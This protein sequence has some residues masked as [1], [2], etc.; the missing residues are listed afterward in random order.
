M[1]SELNNYKHIKKCHKKQ[2]L[3]QLYIV[4]KVVGNKMKY[5]E[6][7]LSEFFVLT[8][9]HIIFLSFSDEAAFDHL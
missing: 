9:P 4:I 8:P 2:I 6:R 7:L 1:L 3:Y 5:F